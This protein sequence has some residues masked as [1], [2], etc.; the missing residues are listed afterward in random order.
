M[1]TRLTFAIV[2]VVLCAFLSTGAGKNARAQQGEGRNPRLGQ[3]FDST[4]YQGLEEMPFLGDIPAEDEISAI[5]PNV[6]V[7]YSHIVF[8]SY[9]NESDWNIFLADGS[10]GNQ[11]Q[12]TWDA[13]ADIHPR[14][15]RGC[16]KIVFATKR[17]GNYDIYTMNLDGSGLTQL[18]SDNH[19]DVYPAWSP[20][21]DAITFQSYRSGNPEVFIMLAD[22]SGQ[23]NLTNSGD[24][25]GM[26]AWS[27]DGRI[28]FSSYRTEQ[29][30]IWVMNRDGSGLTQ[31]TSQPY[32]SFP[33]WSRDGSYIAFTADYDADGWLDLFIMNSDGSNPRYLPS[34]GYAT[35][36][37]ARSWSP[38]S[39]YIAYTQIGYTYEQGNW[40]WVY[41]KLNYFD[42][43]SALSYSIIEALTEWHP[44]W[45]SQDT[46]APE[47]TVLP[48]PSQSPGPIEV[49][50]SG[51]D[52]GPTG[53][54]G[55]DIQVK[56]GI[57]GVWVDWLVRTT[58]TAGLYRA[59][60]GHT[61]FFR[62][63][64][65][66]FGGNLEPWPADYD[67]L[68]RVE[69]YPPTASVN[70]LPR[71]I[72]VRY[73]I[74]WG[75]D[76]IGGSGIASF[77]IQ[78]QDTTWGDWINWKNDTTK[79]YAPLLGLL[80][81]TYHFR[82]RATDK[83][84][85]VG[86]WAYS[87]E[88]ASTMLC[89]WVI[90]GRVQ[91]NTGIPIAN[92]ALT[93]SPVAAAVGMNN[94]NGAY[95]ACVT[96]SADLYTADWSKA[97]YGDLPSTNFDDPL[98]ILDSALPPE[99]NIIPNWGFELTQA[100]SAKTEDNSSSPMVITQTYHTGQQSLRLSQLAETRLGNP[101]Y[102]YH[103]IWSGPS[104]IAPEL[105]LD[106]NGTS[107]LVWVEDDLYIYYSNLSANGQWSAPLIISSAGK[108]E[109]ASPKLL[110]GEN[111]ELHVIWVEDLLT[112][113]QLYYAYRDENGNWADPV[114]LPL[115]NQNWVLRFQ[116]AL[117]PYDN[118]H[119]VWEQ[120]VSSGEGK[121]YYGRREAGGAWIGP[122][123]ISPADESSATEPQIGLDGRGGIH[124]AWKGI[125]SYPYSENI[126]YTVS[127][128][129]GLTWAS[130]NLLYQGSSVDVE[131]PR[132]AV[133]PDGDV[134]LVW[135]VDSSGLKA[136][137]YAR[138]SAGVWSTP[139]VAIPNISTDNSEPEYSLQIQLAYSGKA[140][141]LA[142]DMYN[143]TSYYNE[144]DENGTWGSP[145]EIGV[146]SWSSLKV[147]RF[148]NIYIFKSGFGTASLRKHSATGEWSE[149]EIPADIYNAASVYVNDDG[150]YHLAWWWGESS[151]SFYL[152]YLGFPL[153]EQTE[154]IQYSQTFTVSVN[155]AAPVLSFF[156]KLDEWFAD[157]GNLFT[158][159][160][161]NG[162]IAEMI[163]STTVRTEG[164]TH[165]WFDL[166]PW[167][168]QLITITFTAH[169]TSGSHYL[170]AYLDEVTVG[171]A[172]PDVW[173]STL[174]PRAAMP[175][176]T[177][178]LQL[179]YG[180]RSPVVEALIATITAT[181]PTGLIF[182]SASLT[183]TVNGNVLTW[184]VGDLPAGSGLFTILVTATVA[185]DAALGSYFTVPVQINTATP[186][187]ELVNNQQEYMLFIGRQV[188][189]PLIHH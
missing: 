113:M 97:G 44:D 46:L 110:V 25:D 57:G 141:V 13:A 143:H 132:L 106:Q 43:P 118:L 73:P 6:D 170:W 68:T 91:D 163:L 124:I 54:R 183:P 109:R 179:S 182:E 21:G 98:Q 86:N 48:L 9:R 157:D 7:P 89:N 95:S 180:N 160:L 87:N 38:D 60:G 39:Q 137:L 139:T 41:G 112:P 166:S 120:T 151:S 171:S 11:T 168:G 116:M 49:N 130:P 93:T 61:Y 186:E 15:N 66:D 136:I 69:S 177:V 90:Q 122:Y 65:L 99:N 8:Q 144:Q 63:R 5:A 77:D 175:G 58:N 82:V 88:S 14:L 142:R 121:I 104:T 83:A 138:R 103:T 51:T 81:H 50:W 18:T 149:E 126:Y 123:Q 181:L 55:Y 53:I 169:Q 145:L 153:A 74:E 131:Y 107:H 22:G 178:T 3:L 67:T 185:G 92:A 162:I 161:E 19:D 30:G 176:E 155:M 187:L 172:H 133:D 24:F 156:Y 84:L 164:W 76:D 115:E 150:V 148:D 23:T 125:P 40:Y 71:F 152:T 114:P 52:Y 100:E 135:G 28:V 140:A 16:T 29:W 36:A 108:A 158:V 147:D 134:S 17:T 80:G 167:T 72:P 78:Y 35:D 128:D 2:W 129:F 45:Q 1:K 70:P 32:S 64:A 101:V 75:G 10:G 37:L 173:V 79:T 111:N 62:S 42:F 12:L 31:L 34:G 189:L 47:S 174:G 56:D 27:P 188:F 119:V 94:Q 105:A 117:D 20:D 33:A 96:D 59:T 154:D 159:K 165:D 184:S 26:P 146:T 85:N 127:E 4:S 102:L